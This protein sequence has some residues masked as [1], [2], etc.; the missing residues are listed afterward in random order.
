[1]SDTRRIARHGGSVLLGQFAS[2]A[3]SVTD[4]MVAGRYA[5]TALAALSVAAA[6]YISVFVALIGVLQATLPIWA[7]LNGAK[8]GEKLGYSVRQSL[9]LCLFTALPGIAVLLAP[10]PLLRASDVPA[11]LQGPVQTYLGVLALSLVPALLF[12]LYGALNQ[13]LGR[14]MLVTWLQIGALVLKVPL[15]VWFAF[16][17][18]GL[19]AM[20]LVGCAVATLVVHLAMAG[21]ALTLLRTRELYR[22]FALWRPLEKPDWSHLAAFAR[23]G[24]PAGLAVAVEVTSFTLM[25]L[26]I[27]R[28]GAVASASHQIASSMASVLYMVPL[29]MGIAT[30]ACVSR[31]IGAGNKVAARAA[32]LSGFKL[33]VSMAIG[34]A[35]LLFI[36]NG[37]I[38]HLY[39][40]NPEVVRTAAVL[41]GWVALYHLADATQAMCVFVLRCYRVT[42]APLVIYSVLLWG[43]GLAGGFALAYGGVPGVAPMN[44]PEAFW[45]ASS[46]ALV[47]TAIAFVLLLWRTVRRAGD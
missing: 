36:A 16:G 37:V 39:S 42:L 5:D 11:A 25:A 34:F 41:L 29:S 12:R 17:G 26:L 23:L 13:A 35:A 40:K 27:A 6:I 22:P 8:A 3:F 38:G 7:E 30:S 18:A 19:P 47:L 20:G 32:I 43:L 21:T 28:L 33:A 10:G 14:P 1:M 46:V 45:I 4:T 24:V 9:Y 15:T 31:W 44:T 2:I